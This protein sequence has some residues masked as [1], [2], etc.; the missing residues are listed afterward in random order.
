MEITYTGYVGKIA[1]HNEVYEVIKDIRE[2]CPD[3][4]YGCSTVLGLF[5]EEQGDLYTE[6]LERL[7]EDMDSSK[8]GNLSI[9][10]FPFGIKTDQVFPEFVG[11]YYANNKYGKTLR[12]V[13]NAAKS[14]CGSAGK[15]NISGGVV[16]K[17]LILTDKWDAYM[18][19]RYFAA[20]FINYANK[21][22]ICF[23]FLLVTDFGVTRIPFLNWKRNRGDRYA[24]IHVSHSDSYAGKNVF[25]MLK[26][27]SPVR[28]GSR[29]NA[30]YGYRDSF[31]FVMD[32]TRDE[33]CFKSPFTNIGASNV[34]E[35][36]ETGK[37]S[38]IPNRVMR[39][40]ALS[41][42]GLI[43]IPGQEMVQDVSVMDA[44]NKSAD[45]FGKHFE[46][47]FDNEHPFNHL[48]NAFERLLKELGLK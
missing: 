29:G 47:Y 10:S 9:N 41:V 25:L 12:D 17:V 36:V 38:D 42:A 16:K 20:S 13:L 44:T 6:K 43:N 14:Y 33:Y 18:F 35:K 23:T 4:N 7:A 24:D 46:W 5:M 3:E 15:S 19:R 48:E 8:P 39:N 30:F 31:E 11:I 45:I 2:S 21:Y 37:I 34:P 22:N 28:Y 40:F 32:F 1:D 27:F 26:N